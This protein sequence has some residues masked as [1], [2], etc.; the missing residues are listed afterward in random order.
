MSVYTVNK[1]LYR[2][3]TDAGFLESTRRNPERA[4]A[5]CRLN[6]DELEALISGDVGTLYLMGVHPFLLNT[7]ARQRLFGVDAATY[8]R[9]VRAAEA[10][11]ERGT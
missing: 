2:L 5:A 9:R 10:A 3:E 11:A 1:V 4:L 8:L 7:V 6:A